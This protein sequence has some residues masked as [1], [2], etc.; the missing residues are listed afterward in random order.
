MAGANNNSPL[1]MI[2]SSFIIPFALDDCA[3]IHHPSHF[4]HLM[5]DQSGANSNSPLRIYF[6]SRFSL[7]I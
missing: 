7:K 5:L 3:I 1:V 4:R 2:A 6:F